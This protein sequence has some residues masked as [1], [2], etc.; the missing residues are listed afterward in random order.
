VATYYV[1][2]SGSD[3]AAG[4]SA[5]A[6]WLTIGKALTSGG[7]AAGDTVYIGA[8]TYR[9]VVTASLTNPASEVKFIGDVDGAFTGDPGEV[10]WTSWTTD[11]TTAP[12]T[13]ATING[14]SKNNLTFQKLTIILSNNTSGGIVSIGTGWKFQDCTIIQSR[15]S[16]QVLV[17]TVTAPINLVFDRC[18]ILGLVASLTQA[19][20]I[21]C[22]ESASAEYDC[23]VVIKNCLVAGFSYALIMGSTG[24]NTFKGGGGKV[25][26][27]TLMGCG[28]VF[29]TSSSTQSIAYPAI[30]V[31]N[32]TWGTLTVFGSVTNGATIG[33]NNRLIGSG[34]PADDANSPFFGTPATFIRYTGMDF[35]QNLLY[36][37]Q[38]RMFGSPTPT[39]ASTS[40]TPPIEVAVQRGGTGSDDATVGTIS[41]TSP[42]NADKAGDGTNATATTIPATTGVTHYL[43]VVGGITVPSGATIKGV[44]VELVGFASA[45]SALS[46]SSVKLVKA[47]TISGNDGA[48]FNTTNISTGAGRMVWRS[49]ADPLWGLTLSDTDVNDAG[50]GCV[51]SLKNTSGSTRDATIEYV[52]VIVVYEYDAGEDAYDLLNRPRPSG[53]NQITGQV[54]ALEVHDYGTKETSVTHGGAASLKLTGPG[55]QQFDVPVDAASTT[56]TAYMRYDTTHGTGTKPQMIVLDAPDI[57]VTTATATMT[58][59]VDTWEQLTLT[60]TPSAKGIVT[61][62][63]RN[64]AAAASGL[65]YV[66]DVAVS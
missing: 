40:A 31:N 32:V 56:I 12:V 38:P 7:V 37:L 17:Q 53:S 41:W 21:T 36:G 57:G 44:R 25:A 13:G 65:A 47:G 63:F 14:G 27:C 18:L 9:E 54:G 1:R 45:L 59:G 16:T 55:D 62:R 42:T 61:I 5:G 52:R 26:N 51:I 66:D 46:M 20:Q 43:K 30:A 6:A 24:S 50:F 28:A 4:T 15:S 48:S 39:S 29:I 64:R 35:G 49:T 2:K 58:V 60:F 33:E 10:I 34:T 3:G 23:G 22:T 8:G 19:V 11:D